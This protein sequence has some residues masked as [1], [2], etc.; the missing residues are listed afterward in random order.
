MKESLITQIVKELKSNSHT[1]DMLIE[2][3]LMKSPLE[4]VTLKNKL[5][6]Q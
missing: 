5:K 2:T 4:L 6:A 1:I 3:L